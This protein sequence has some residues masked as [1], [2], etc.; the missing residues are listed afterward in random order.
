VSTVKAAAAVV[1]VIAVAAV[2]AGAQQQHQEAER[3][4]RVQSELCL[5]KAIVAFLSKIKLL[6]LSSTSTILQ[7]GIEIGALS[8]MVERQH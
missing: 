4:C 3:L 1:A 5:K 8:E 2:A 7:D 6:R